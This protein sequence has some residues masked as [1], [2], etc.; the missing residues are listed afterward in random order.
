[1]SKNVQTTVQISSLYMVVR[2]CS[3]SL[4]LGFSSRWIENFQI[5]EWVYRR[6]RNQ[7]SN[8]EYSLVHRRKH[9]NSR[10]ISIS[11][12]LSTLKPLCGSQKLW[13]IL[14]DRNTR[15]LYLSPE[16]HCMQV[17]KQQ[18]ELGMEKWTFKIEKGV[19]QACILSPCLFNLYAEYIMRHAGLD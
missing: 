16:K 8:C 6:Q 9:E 13:K 11:A 12:S 10:K 15:Q 17:K 5:Y 18:L 4:K 3:K 2:L 19:S 14:R 1:M 7:R